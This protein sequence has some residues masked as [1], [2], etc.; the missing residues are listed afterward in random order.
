DWS[1]DVCSSDL[2]WQQHERRPYQLMPDMP[3]QE[4]LEKLPVQIGNMV[5]SKA[6]LSPDHV[7][8]VE[9]GVSW[10][11][12]ELDCL[13]DQTRTW[14]AGSGIRPGDRLVIVC[15]NCRALVALF[16]ATVSMDA[17]PVL[18]NAQLSAREIEQIREHCGARLVLY[19]SAS[20]P[21]A[22]EHAKKFGATAVTLVGLGQISI[23]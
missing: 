6:E 3:I 11:Y 7:A 18:V 12:A 4:I 14:L 1:S 16:L 21:Q 22:N 2:A 19:T 10:T 13:V 9:G 15:E 23:G 5:K 17:W 20:S 8:L